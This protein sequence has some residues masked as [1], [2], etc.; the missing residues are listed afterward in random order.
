[1][2]KTGDVMYILDI[3]NSLS[4]GWRGDTEADRV[5]IGTYRTV[6]GPEG[7]LGGHVMQGSRGHGAHGPNSYST[8]I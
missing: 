8:T 3:I 6:V 2:Y 1:M 5:A 4:G 7:S